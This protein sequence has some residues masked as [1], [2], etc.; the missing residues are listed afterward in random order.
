VTSIVTQKWRLEKTMRADRLLAIIMLL[1]SR[2]KMTTH[3]LAKELDV[4]RRT[5]LRDV[6]ALSFL[7]VPIYAEGGHGG[8]VTLDENYRTSLIGLHEDE[9]RTLFI[10]SNSKLLRDVGLG[11]AA[12]RSLQKLAANVPARYA[13]S[14]DQFR[15]RILIDPSWWWEDTQP[16]A[17][18][19]E[20]Q[21]A[22]YEDRLIQTVYER[23]S[24][25]IV[26]RTLEPYSLVAKSSIW[27]LIA[28]RDGA[29]RTYRVSRFRHITVLASSFERDTGYDLQTYWQKHLAEFADTIPDY[30]FTLRIRPNRMSFLQW[31][32]PGRYKLDEPPDNDEWITVHFQL[33]SIELAKMLVFGL[34]ADHTE[35]I[36]PTELRAA[37]LNAARE[38]CDS[39]S[40]DS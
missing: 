15:Q 7:G 8:G 27:Y 30:R 12:E 14:V 28:R 40:E 10:A 1:Q 33:E 6:D 3:T 22:V 36:E 37:V 34:G 13:P 31:I 16:I 38:F 32:V 18:W 21:R 11:E 24:G 19:E 4:S 25:E 35:I 23:Y 17:F 26:K 39:T 2:G 20:L 9:I 5:I 29:F